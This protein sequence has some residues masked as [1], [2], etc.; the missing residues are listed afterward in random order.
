MTTIAGLSPAMLTELQAVAERKVT[1][2]VFGPRKASY[3]LGWN[4]TRTANALH[5]RELITPGERQIGRRYST[6]ELT[7]AGRA[8][9]DRLDGAS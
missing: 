6:W 4:V 9:L 3:H 2:E 7:D 1:R 5:R 8:L